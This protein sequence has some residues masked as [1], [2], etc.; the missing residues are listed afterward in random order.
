MRGRLA[1]AFLLVAALPA[2]AAAAGRLELVLPRPGDR[3]RPAEFL[4]GLA[5]SGLVPAESIR[6]PLRG[7]AAGLLLEL[8]VRDLPLAPGAVRALEAAGLGEILLQ[9]FPDGEALRIVASA[10]LAPSAPRPPFV[11]ASLRPPATA[12]DQC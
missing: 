7:E 6:R 3:S 11:N 12:D 9:A 1:F 10:A 8:G 4:L 5:S 2:P